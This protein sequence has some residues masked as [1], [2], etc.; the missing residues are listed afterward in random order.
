M[1]LAEEIE[2]A[3]K[4]IRDA[5]LLAGYDG[6]EPDSSGE[7]LAARYVASKGANVVFD[8]GAHVGNWLKACRTEF[9]G[10][11]IFHC[12]E[13][14][15]T[16][17]ESLRKNF[18]EVPHA[19]LNNLAIS[20]TTGSAEMHSWVDGGSGASLVKR[21]LAHLKEERDAV[22]VVQTIKL[23]EYCKG[24]G[25]NTIDFLKLDVE[26]WEFNIVES[27]LDMIREGRVRFIQ[28]EYGHCNVDTRTFLK[29]FYR[30]LRIQYDFYRI[31]PRGLYLCN[32]YK[33]DYECFRLTNY[34]MELRP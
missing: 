3:E 22:E 12:F 1:R 16:A 21:D 15:K 2:K 17:F 9:S 26:G 27:A 7:I 6:C 31:H 14:Q 34:L 28:I 13:P 24:N 23:N 25:I 18:E 32:D 33:E 19:I 30:L 5:A 10:D 29:D 11:T 4:M 8:V 20:S